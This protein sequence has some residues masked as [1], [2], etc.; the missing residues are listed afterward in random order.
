MKFTIHSYSNE[1]KITQGY[2]HIGNT[3]LA[4]FSSYLK[5]ILSFSGGSNALGSFCN[6]STEAVT[7][8]G[9]VHHYEVP[10]ESR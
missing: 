8:I 2:R 1:K 5:M 9:I 6:L 7:T 3:K 4:Q 10:H